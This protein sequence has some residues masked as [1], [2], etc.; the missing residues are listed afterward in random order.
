MSLT[1]LIFNIQR[2]S[3]HDGPGI[4]T[5]VFFKGCSLRCFWCHNPE[6]LRPGMEIQFNPDRCIVCGEC[7]EA[8]PEGAHQ[9]IDGLHRYDRLLCQVCGTCLNTCYTGALEQVGTEYTVEQVLAEVLRDRPFYQE[10]HGGVTLSGGDPLVQHEFSLALLQACKQ[11]ELHT[12]IETAA[13]CRWEILERMLPFVDLVLMDLKHL[14]PDKH[15]KAT[16]V[17][18]TR[19]LENAARLSQT[20]KPVLFRTPVVPGVNDTPEEIS[21]IARFVHSISPSTNG[22][23][24]EGSPRLELLPFHKL[25]AGKY[26]SLGLEYPPASLVPPSAEKMRLLV[27][28]ARGEGIKVK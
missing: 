5:T 14:D 3:I 4:R 21:A 23:E 27:E 15:Q 7:V 22:H 11:E 20:G 24:N 9:I 26:N 16:G 17:P 19:I 8:C 1:G 6:G 25:A 12:A 10:S 2:F 18:N 13:N 28:A